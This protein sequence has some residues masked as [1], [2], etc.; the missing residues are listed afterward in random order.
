VEI[1]DDVPN[2]LGELSELDT[3][4]TRLIERVARHAPQIRR[5]ASD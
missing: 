3:V 4:R 2:D 5:D 1:T